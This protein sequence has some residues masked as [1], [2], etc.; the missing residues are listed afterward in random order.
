MVQFSCI[1]PE[2]LAQNLFNALWDR[3]N[4][5]AFVNFFCFFSLHRLREKLSPEVKLDSMDKILSQTH[6]VTNENLPDLSI[7][8]E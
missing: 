8:H 3:I 1:P 4:A 6:G 5:K 7:W 2:L